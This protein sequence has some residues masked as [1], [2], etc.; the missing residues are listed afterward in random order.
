LQER[1]KAFVIDVHRA[2]IF[3]QDLIGIYRIY[4]ISRILRNL[5]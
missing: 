3:E 1:I 2:F 5:D 4:R